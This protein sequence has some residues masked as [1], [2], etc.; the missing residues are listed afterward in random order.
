MAVYWLWL[1]KKIRWAKIKSKL[2]WAA[3]MRTNSSMKTA[4]IQLWSRF[5]QIHL[6]VAMLA[7]LI[8]SR[9]MSK[10]ET[11]LFWCRVWTGEKYSLN[12]TLL[13][14]SSSLSPLVQIWWICLD[15]SISKLTLFA[16][17]QLLRTNILTLRLGSRRCRLELIFLIE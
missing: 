10:E 15:R 14:R 2:C 13:I 11:C 3:T 7:V 1:Y 17:I 16:F 6:F 5:N 12:S 4:L 9:P 8:R